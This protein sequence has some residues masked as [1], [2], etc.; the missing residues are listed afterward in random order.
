VK[1]V[2][3]VFTGGL[4]AA[5][6]AFVDMMVGGVI[7]H[8]PWLRDYLRDDCV[9]I[10]HS[11]CCFLSFHKLVCIVSLRCT[12]EWREHRQGGGGVCGRPVPHFMRLP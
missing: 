4:A 6:R 10:F 1:N 8:L 11:D 12:A 5:G 9:T 2:E 7:Q 3:H